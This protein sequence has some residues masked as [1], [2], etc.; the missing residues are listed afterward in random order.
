MAN[1]KWSEI[2]SPPPFKFQE[3]GDEIQ[4]EY[5]GEH[6]TEFEG[7]KVKIY[8]INTADKG[9]VGVF[10]CTIL[11]RLMHDKRIVVGKKVRIVYEGDQ[12]L[13]RGR[14]L[15]LFKVYVLE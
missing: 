1:E 13:G 11:D 15:R 3:K 6:E 14:R 8:D 7:R 5:R 2:E 9:I 10:G 12:P 4:G